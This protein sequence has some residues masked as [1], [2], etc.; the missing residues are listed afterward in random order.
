MRQPH[1]KVGQNEAE[2]GD[3]VGKGRTQESLSK[4]RHPAPEKG[5]SH[6]K[7][8]EGE[9]RRKIAVVKGSTLK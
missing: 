7:S 8:P 2:G 1:R 9:V 4:Q 5:K 3:N 6:K